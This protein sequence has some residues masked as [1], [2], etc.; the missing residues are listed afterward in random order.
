MI[1]QTQFEWLD[2]FVLLICAINKGEN[3]NERLLFL[4]CQFK[5]EKR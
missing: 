4:K 2:F 1:Q 5:L 3:I